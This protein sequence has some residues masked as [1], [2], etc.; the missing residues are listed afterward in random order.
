MEEVHEIDGSYCPTK[1][2]GDRMTLERIHG[3]T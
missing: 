2:L 1:V 3:V